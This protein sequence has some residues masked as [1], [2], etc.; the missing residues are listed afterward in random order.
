VEALWSW[1]PSV[2]LYEG[3]RRQ[4]ELLPSRL[5]REQEEHRDILAALE[6]RDAAQAEAATRQHIRN[7]LQ[8]LAEVLGVSPALAEPPVL[9]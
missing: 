9:H 5:A 4:E 6:Q 8:E 2:M 3:M 1:F 7:L